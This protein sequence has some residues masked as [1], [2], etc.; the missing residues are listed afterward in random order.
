LPFQYSPE[1]RQSAIER[2]LDGL[3]SGT[4]L[5]VICREDG[6]PWDNTIRDWAEADKDLSSAIARAR[7]AGFDKIAMDA[8]AIADE[9]S[10][11]TIKGENGEGKPNS[12]WITRSRL[13]VE[14]RLKLLA[15]WDP[16]RYGDATM[17]KHADANGEKMDM[18]D[19]ER[20]T[21]LAAIFA[22]IE[23]RKAEN[24]PE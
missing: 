8:L 21:R 19:V 10:N 17:I 24:E 2:V 7:E 3:A 11:D 12:E 5:A 23:Q 14:T 16:K 20:A 22:N 15:K 4:P 6:M 9:V 18:G 1:A 13:R